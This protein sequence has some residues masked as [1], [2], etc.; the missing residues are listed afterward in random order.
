[1]FYMWPAL[2]LVASSLAPNLDAVVS[3][4]VTVFLGLLM[5][6]LNLA[7]YD[8]GPAATAKQVAGS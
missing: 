3:Q 5:S 7:R 1:M 6:N 8:E 2:L 4:T